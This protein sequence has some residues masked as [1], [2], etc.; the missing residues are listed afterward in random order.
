MPL[1]PAGIT[2]NSV[3]DMLTWF[4][5]VFDGISCFA[6]QEE[7][8][9]QEGAIPTIDPPRKC[10]IHLRDKI[11]AGLEDMEKNG[12][13]RPVTK[14]TKWCSSLTYALK[15]DTSIRM[16]IDPQ[17]LNKSLVKRP[18]KIPTIEEITPLFAGAKFFTKLDAK[19]GYW[20]VKLA[21]ESQELTT[22]RTPF[23]RYCFLRLPFGLSISQD[24]FQERMDRITQQCKGC[25]GISDDIVIFGKS[26]L[27]HDENLVNFLKVAHKEGLMLN[28]AK[29]MVK[30]TSIVFFGRLYTDHGVFPDP[31]KVEDILRMPTPQDKLDLQRFLGLATFLS[32]H[33]PNLSAHAAI[34]RDLV[35]PET[36]YEWSEDHQQAFKDLKQLISTKIGLQYY[37]PSKETQLEVDASIRGLGAALIQDQKPVA[38]ASKAL[39]PAQSNYSNIERECLGV[40]HGIQRFHHFLFGRRFTVISDCKPLETIFQKALHAAPPRL[41]RMMIKV[42]GY[43]FD[44]KYRPGP[45]MVLADTL[46][47]LPNPANNEEMQLEYINTIKQ[48]QD[49]ISMDLMSFSTTKQEEIRQETQR[50]QDLSALAQVIFSGWPERIQDV[51]NQLREYWSY[52]DELAVENGIII[53]GK[54]V[55]IPGTVRADILRQLHEGHQGIE[56]T[57]L[58]ARQAVYWPRIHKDI[59][60]MVQNCDLCQEARP[61]QA[62][63]PMMMIEKPSAPWV[64]LGTDLF[65]T[66][67]KDYL[68][69]A[70]Y[71]SLYPVVKELQSMT[72]AAVI[73]ATKEILSMFGTPKEI[74]SDNGPCFLTDYKEFCSKWGVKHTT[75]SPRHPQGNGFIENR[76]KVTKQTITK[77]LKSGEDINRALLNIHATPINNILPSPAELLFGRPITMGMPNHSHH[78]GLEPHRTELHRRTEVQ[79]MYADHHTKQLPPLVTGQHVRVLDKTDNH[80]HPARVVGQQSDRSYIIEKPGGNKL[81]RNRVQLKEAMPPRTEA[82]TTETPPGPPVH[83]DHGSPVSER[84]N[85]NKSNPSTQVPMPVSPTQTHQQAQA[86]SRSGRV[87]KTPE[88]YKD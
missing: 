78:L 77:C 41:Q 73:S 53:K 29:C 2:I 25:T 88:R 46:S 7:L 31:E 23:G 13:I 38:F 83:T 55:L 44:V 21:P 65:S 24:A 70:D 43:D 75:T 62:K 16:C 1:P 35:R 50:D 74:I 59:E 39:N 45:Q 60:A 18:H 40:I 58:L 33:L 76:V 82:A 22:F 72:A 37:D 54:Q 48:D 85:A 42:Q 80:W 79:K 19:A 8:H 61:H 68:I 47:R 9:I 36:P 49:N 10:P 66:G 52:R 4:P 87:I 86:R 17:N 5:D 69:I 57:R 15:K 64:K 26:E 71:Y 6:G 12:I 84:T 28:S 67:G 34:L 27:E 63:E 3:K 11:K 32:D 20:G 81:R 14:P 56:K 30:T 51:P